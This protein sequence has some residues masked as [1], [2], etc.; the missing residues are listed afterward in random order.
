M[1]VCVCVCVCERVD[2]LL[3]FIET[4]IWHRFCLS[5]K[6][7]P[8]TTANTTCTACV[9]LC[10]SWRCTACD[11]RDIRGSDIRLCALPGHAGER[12]EVVPLL[13]LHRHTQTHRQTHRQTQIHTETHTHT[14]TQTDT[15]THTHTDRHRHRHTDT[16]THTHTS[17]LFTMLA[18]TQP[19]YDVETAAAH[20]GPVRK[21]IAAPLRKM[22]VFQR[23]GTIVPRKM[24]VRRCVC[25]NVCM[26]V[27]VFG[28]AKGA[29][30]SPP[31]THI[32]TFG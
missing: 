10:C 25:V 5:H 20:V 11:T 27:C 8:S 14:H 19:W 6:P 18:S 24:R 3:P 22:P 26:C 13:Q 2:M 15:D 17:S 16:D 4:L 23:G 30:H 7:S 1:C 32:H 29:R 12:V 31:H 9:L 21:S 28:G